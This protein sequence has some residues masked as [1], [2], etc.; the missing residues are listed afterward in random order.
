V[1]SSVRKS[2]CVKHVAQNSSRSVNHVSGT[3][4]AARFAGRLLS[5]WAG[6]SKTVACRHC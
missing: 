2:A 1:K 5:L 6:M 4:K 3:A